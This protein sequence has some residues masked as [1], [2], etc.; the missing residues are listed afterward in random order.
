MG[1]LC[2]NNTGMHLNALQ[3]T[4]LPKLKQIGSPGNWER[5]FLMSNTDQNSMELRSNSTSSFKGHL[6][7]YMMSL[8]FTIFLNMLETGEH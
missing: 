7:E 6:S 5:I 3:I 1:F 4:G 2:N 8:N